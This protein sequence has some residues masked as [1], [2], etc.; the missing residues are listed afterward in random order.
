L[1]G[2]HK[3]TISRELKL[4]RNRGLS[5]YRPKQ[6]QSLADNRCEKKVQISIPKETWQWVERL[7]KDNW[8]PEQ[9]SDWEADT[10]HQ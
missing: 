6:A 7:L 1:V 8:S 5:G 9:I 2:C 10:V 3:S 4:K